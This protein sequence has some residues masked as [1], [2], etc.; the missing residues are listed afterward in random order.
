M[1]SNILFIM[2]DAAEKRENGQKLSFIIAPE[3]PKTRHN[4]FCLRRSI[5]N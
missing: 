3:R 4:K 2:M 1:E 5:L